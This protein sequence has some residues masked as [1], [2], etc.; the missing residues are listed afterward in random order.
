MH[1]NH[2]VMVFGRL[3]KLFKIPF[4]WGIR[5]SMTTDKANFKK[6][7]I[8][9]FKPERH[10]SSWKGERLYIWSFIAHTLNQVF[11]FAFEEK[12]W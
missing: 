5:V 2:G 1:I 11:F 8:V 9:W 6:S 3:S 7:K 12:A 10:N 4:Q